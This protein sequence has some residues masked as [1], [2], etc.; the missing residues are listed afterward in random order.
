VSTVPS[1]L[2]RREPMRVTERHRFPRGVSTVRSS[3]SLERR[4]PMRVTERR[5]FPRGV[6]TVPSSLERREPMR[7]TERRRFPREVSTAPSSSARRGP[8]MGETGR[9][10]K[11]PMLQSSSLDH[12]ERWTQAIAHRRCCSSTAAW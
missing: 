5:R 1:S 8:R 2:E 4:E 10:R 7:V 11:A 9:R 3:L 6:S 12:L